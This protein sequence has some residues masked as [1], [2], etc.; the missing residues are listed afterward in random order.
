MT[1]WINIFPDYPDGNKIKL[2]NLL[3]HT[4]GIYN[5]TI[6][7]GKEDSAIVCHP[8]KKSLILNIFYHKPLDF[9]PGTK[10]KYDN[11][12]YYLLGMIIEKVTGKP[13]EQV[14][15]KLLF[16]P[17]HMD[18]SGFDFLNLQDT[19]KATGYDKLSASQQVISHPWD[20]TV[21]YAAGGIYSTSGDL[22]KWAKAIADKQILTENSW[23]QAFT[24]N[25]GNYGYGWWIDSLLGQKYVMHT[26]GGFG[27]MSFFIY[28]PNKDITIILLNNFGDYGES[29]W[30]VSEGIAAILFNKPY[31]LWRKHTAIKISTSI[32]RQYTG[33]YITNNKVKLYITLKNGQL[34]AKS[35]SKHGL[36]KTPICAENENEFFLKDFDTLFTFIK[37]TDGKVSKMISH[38]N[39][40][41]VILKKIK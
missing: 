35:S 4:S 22:Y 19:S 37:N 26:G 10:F 16:D 27:F 18:H 15:R 13:Y 38:E 30:P 39:G 12:G 14:V 34:Y 21:S 23:K 5:Y 2:K 40:K 33:I 28:F 1:L 24:P 36:P 25:L 20:S 17:L 8:V 29:L 31:N 11:S 32:L 41:N 6:D 7:I 3:D 9:A